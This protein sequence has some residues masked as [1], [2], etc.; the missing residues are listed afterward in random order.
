MK[1]TADTNLLVRMAVRDDDAQ[2]RIA[3]GILAKAQTIIV[4]LPCI[5]EFVW[6]LESIY[7]FTNENVIDAL[8]ALIDSQNVL[9]DLAAV[10][11]GFRVMRQGG[12]FADGV[13]ASAGA[14]MGADA[15]VSFDRKAI[16]C[17]ASIGLPARHAGDFA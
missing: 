4:P 2:A 8:T 12:D 7:K 9:T 13:I 5:L 14:G 11:T 3:F 1:V 15:F 6:V 10:E 16:K 17:I